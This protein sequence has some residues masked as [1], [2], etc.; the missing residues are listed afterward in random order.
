MAR[1]Y[2]FDKRSKSQFKKDIKAAHRVEADIAV[3]IC[4]SIYD[5][6]GEWPE[7]VPNG[8]DVSGEFISNQKNVSHAP[9]FEIGGEMVEITHSR[10]ECKKPYF[11]QKESKVKQC[12]ENNWGIVFVHGIH[13]FKEPKYVLMNNRTLKRVSKKA[14]DKYGL[15]P[16]PT[17]NGVVN[18]RSYRYDFDFFRDDE[19]HLLPPI[20]KEA[21]KE[22]KYI[23]DLVK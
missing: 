6:Y 9:D 5:E 21:S 3:R 1:N 2:R 15:V 22:Y 4:Q 19:W 11:H 8:S 20:S 14:V 16:H 18:K 23:L 10:S 13:A 17:R 7:L 12:L